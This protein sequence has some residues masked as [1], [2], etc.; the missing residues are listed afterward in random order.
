LH[1]GPG[2][3]SPSGHS[4]FCQLFLPPPFWCVTSLWS[5]RISECTESAT[6]VRGLCWLP[7][8]SAAHTLI[9][10]NGGTP[11]GTG[12][13]GAAPASVLKVRCQSQMC[14]I[15]LLFVPVVNQSQTKRNDPPCPVCEYSP[16]LS[17]QNEAVACQPWSVVALAVIRTANGRWE[18]ATA[19][20][21]CTCS[22]P[23]GMPV[24]RQR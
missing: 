1:G 5:P 16:G 22:V 2:V 17:W 12:G 9:E 4:G 20:K 6:S 15:A 21:R 8:D 23:H 13:A 24:D 19:H 3:E 11:A 18:V 14:T 7:V 10:S